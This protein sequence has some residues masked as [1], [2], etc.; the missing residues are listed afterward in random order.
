MKYYKIILNDT[1]VGAITSSNFIRYS[2][3]VSCFLS[4]DETTGEY[5]DYKGQRYRCPWMLPTT[6][7]YSFIEATILPIEEEE[8]NILAAAMASDEVIPAYEEP[9]P[10]PDPVYPEPFVSIEDQATLQFVRDSKITEMSR[11]CR[12][13]IEGGIDI[14]LQD[15]THHFSLDTQD[16]LNLISLGAMADT[17]ELIPYHADGEICKFYTAAEI[18]SIVAAATAH[19][20]YHTTYYNALKGYINSL[21]TIQEISEIY[22]GIELPI[23]YQSDVYRVITN[24]N[25][26]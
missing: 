6:T 1:V 8:Y 19:K 4:A 9:E 23:A 25:A 21:E 17:Q 10:I 16:Q 13:V 14:E 20:I 24:E 5:I 12:T 22:Y 11:T 26:T 3:Q 2:S 18:K 15:G 7:D